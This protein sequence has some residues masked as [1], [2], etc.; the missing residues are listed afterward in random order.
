MTPIAVTFFNDYTARVKREE[1]IRLDELVAAIRSAS[2]SAKAGLP[3]LKLARFGDRRSDK[4]SLRHDA[5][6]VSISGIEADYDGEQLTFDQAVERLDKAG[7]T[8]VVYTS[9]SNTPAR[10]RWRVLCPLSVEF[11]PDRRNHLMSRLNGLFDGIFA[12]ESWSLSQSYYFGSVN[13]SPHHRVALVDGTTTL[14]RAD[15]L[16]AGAIGKP[17]GAV[18]PQ[19]PGEPSGP[20]D[21]AGLVEAIVSGQAYH[22]SCVRLVGKWAQAGMPF[23]DAQHR[24]EALFDDVFPGDRD[25]RWQERRTDIPRIIRDIYGKEAGKLDGHVEFT[26]TGNARASESAE[27]AG[28]ESEAGPDTEPEPAATVVL[29]LGQLRD[30]EFGEADFLLG[31]LLSTT[32][33]LELIGPTG[34]G[35]SNLLF[36]MT[37]AIADGQHFL[38]WSAGRAAR[39]L[40]VDGEMSARLLRERAIDA[41]RRANCLPDNLFFLSHAL[42][43]DLQPLNHPAG[44]RFI[45]EQI[46]L[47]GG[48]DLV[49]FDNVQCLL[50]GDMKDELTWQQTLP[51]VRS[52]TNRHI[53]QVWVHHTGHDETHGYGTKTREWQLDTV[54]LLQR[55]EPGVADIR[56]RLEFIKA[57]ERTPDNRA[58][59]EPRLIT[60]A[61]DEWTSEA[62]EAGG[63]GGGRHH[64]AK[65][66]ALELLHDEIARHGL[67][68]Q[69][70]NEIP[71]IVPCVTEERWRERFVR[72]NIS[73][74]TP[75]SVRKAFLRAAQALVNEGRVGKRDPWV[76]VVRR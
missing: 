58:D 29:T 60:L 53:G 69:F 39:V 24:L 66:R 9:P 74:G 5:N 62:V 15:E 31:E 71:S 55:E 76:W 20:L 56:F 7:I 21:E 14:D 16:D 34:I 44:Q 10:P 54:L 22:T 59:F 46:A 25:Q 68:P 36:A 3:W 11:P 45:D 61:G 63:G 40:Y 65:D 26:I 52:L 67:I 37:L 19:T 1:S 23:L 4:D 32:S 6:I 12:A 41:A 30:A 49:I 33:R 64:S 48:V 75:E 8:A 47:I 70:D 35:K 50:V 57:R 2:T 13:G 28:S 43:E 72:A 73:D 51:W 18:R 38:H 42:C 17:N 27:S